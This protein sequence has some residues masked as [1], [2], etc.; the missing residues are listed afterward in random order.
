LYNDIPYNISKKLKLP[1]IDKGL[2]L[3]IEYNNG[4]Y[5]IV[6][7]KYRTNTQEVVTYTELST[8]FAQI[9]QQDRNHGKIEAILMTNTENVVTEVNSNKVRAFTNSFFEELDEDFFKDLKIYV[10]TNAKPV[11]TTKVLRKF[12]TECVTKISDYLETSS[13]AHIIN[14]CGT[15]K[16]IIVYHVDRIMTFRKTVIFVPSLYLLSQMYMTFVKEANGEYEYLLIGSDADIEEEY[17]EVDIT[18]DPGVIR[19]KFNTTKKLIVICT[20]QSSELLRNYEFE[21]GI[22]DEAHRTVGNSESC[23]SFALYDENINIVR[24][25]FVTATKKVYFGSN[26]EVLCMNNEEIYGPLVFEYNIRQAIDEGYLCDYLIEIMKIENVVV[27]KYKIENKHIDTDGDV[28]GAHYVSCMLMIRQ[29]FERNLINHLLTF[30]SSINKA[31]DFSELLK[32][33]LPEVKIYHINGSMSCKTRNKIIKS[34]KEDPC[35]IITSVNALNEGVD[36]PIFDS[37]CF[38]EGRSSMINIIQCIGRAL[39]LHLGK[40]CARILIPVVETELDEGTVFENLIKIIKTLSV[41]DSSVI[42]YFK[43]RTNG[44]EVNKKLINVSNFEEGLEVDIANIDI[45]VFE[46]KIDTIVYDH[47]FNRV[48][49]TT[50]YEQARKII[51]TKGIKNKHEYYQCC[52]TVL[53]KDPETAFKGRFTNWIE[54]LSIERVFYNLEECREKVAELLRKNPELKNNFLEIDKICEKLCSLDKM[55]PPHG[56]WCEYYEIE[57][58]SKLVNISSKKKIICEKL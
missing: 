49:N 9:L 45:S 23:F 16:S 48:V 52:S 27:E 35:A 20:Y 57:D 25:L 47:T 18:T 19:E 4:K 51:K 8:F 26:E 54:Y 58:I 11:Y 31:I 55:F 39:R 29:L 15:G 38:V 53:P 17:R 33:Y 41:Y 13:R 37:V 5:G 3:L 7:C 46:N 12:Q 10:K 22:F 42:E 28:Y 21:F 1:K 6:Q 32:K 14:A 36:I 24:R 2:D 34:F 50:T 56:L 44:L 30:H 40:M 43:A